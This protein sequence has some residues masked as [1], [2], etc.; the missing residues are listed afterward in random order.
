MYQAD[1]RDEARAP[2]C[3]H[4]WGWSSE[5]SRG[6]RRVIGPPAPTVLQK[7]RA[8]LQ[9]AGRPT[10]S[11]TQ[12]HLVWC[13]AGCGRSPNTSP[14]YNTGS[15]LWLFQVKLTGV[16]FSFALTSLCC[17]LSVHTTVLYAIFCACVHRD[18]KFSYK[19]IH[20]HAIDRQNSQ[21]P[22]GYWMNKLFPITH[23]TTYANVFTSKSDQLLW[24]PHVTRQ[25]LGISHSPVETK[26]ILKL[27]N[28]VIW[29]LVVCIFSVLHQS[30][31]FLNLSALPSEA[32]NCTCGLV[33]PC[34]L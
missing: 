25:S 10:V 3:F 32:L 12:W 13:C 6:T 22:P 19:S 24:H 17:F 5:S 16:I 7:F 26:C 23:T 15:L 4:G 27:S 29:S 9:P 28:I 20:M 8:F 14:P 1:K 33:F 21:P 31:D 11:Q 34:I 18:P 2:L 30:H